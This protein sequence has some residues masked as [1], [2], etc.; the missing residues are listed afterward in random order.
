MQRALPVAPNARRLPTLP[1]TTFLVVLILLSL[2]VSPPVAAIAQQARPTEEGIQE[3]LNAM[4]PEKREKLLEQ[5][6]HAMD[7]MN[8]M[9]D[10]QSGQCTRAAEVQIKAVQDEPDSIYILSEM[11]RQG[12][13]VAKNLDLF[14]VNLERAA[15]L[16]KGNAT[17]DLGYYFE[18]G[19]EGYSKAIDVS[20]QWYEKAIR[21]GEPRAMVLLGRLLLKGEGI[22]KNTRRAVQL[23]NTAADMSAKNIDASNAALRQLSYYY[24]NGTD[25]PPNPSLGRAYALRGAAQCDGISM[26]LVAMT[27]KMQTH[28]DFIQAYAWL[29][30]ASQHSED[31][32]LETASN[33]RKELAG[34][35]NA[36]AIAAAEALTGKLPVCLPPEKR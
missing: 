23:F 33:L 4:P 36:S 15:K 9:S 12:W 27:F 22:Q 34:A 1:R 35:I 30:A 20:A 11:Y 17:T 24:L 14:H 5:L 32:E 10:L 13:C 7:Q 25:A 6:Q 8:L 21:I 26:T 18:T 19:T 31:Q 3:R 2:A 16:G 28:P 29:N